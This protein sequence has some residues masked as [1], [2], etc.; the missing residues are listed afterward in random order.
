MRRTWEDLSKRSSSN[1]QSRAVNRPATMQEQVNFYRRGV[2][3]RPNFTLYLYSTAVPD[4]TSETPRS[5]PYLPGRERYVMTPDGKQFT[6]RYIPADAVYVVGE[7]SRDFT[8][9]FEVGEHYNAEDDGYFYYVAD[10]TGTPVVPTWEEGQ[11]ICHFK[12]EMP[13][14]AL[15]NAERMALELLFGG[16]LD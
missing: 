5:N 11:D 9:L 3:A 10:R 16:W 1:A 6:E 7:A 13:T 15:S 8:E 12:V 4:F 14:W 2:Q